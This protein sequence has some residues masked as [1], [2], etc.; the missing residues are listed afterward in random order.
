VVAVKDIIEKMAKALVDH[1]DEVAVRVIEGEQTTIL[2]LKVAQSDI[3]KVVGKH[4]RTIRS[5]RTIL[6][7]GGMKSKKRFVLE[8]LDPKDSAEQEEIGMNKKGPCVRVRLI[9]PNGETTL[10]L[11]FTIEADAEARYE[12]IV[13]ACTKDRW[14]GARVQCLDTFGEIVHEHIIST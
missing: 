2:E 12:R 7:A 14:F 9:R 5:I 11:E 4:G 10:T 6:N 1:P 8:V 3:G 13:D